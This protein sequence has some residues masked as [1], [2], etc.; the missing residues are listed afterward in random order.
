MDVIWG[1][2][3]GHKV[4]HHSNS[5]KMHQLYYNQQI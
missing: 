5:P 3:K 2:Y 4:S 1:K